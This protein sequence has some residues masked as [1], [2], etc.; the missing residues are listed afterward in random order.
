MTQIGLYIYKI[1]IQI[2]LPIFVK[3]PVLYLT[4]AIDRSQLLMARS[5]LNPRHAGSSGT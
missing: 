5:S 4:R 1:G 3:E 2:S